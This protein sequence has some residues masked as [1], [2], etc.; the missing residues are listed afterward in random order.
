VYLRAETQFA[1]KDLFES[2][3]RV[4]RQSTTTSEHETK[5]SCPQI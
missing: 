2:K 4:L 5:E 3:W 1:D